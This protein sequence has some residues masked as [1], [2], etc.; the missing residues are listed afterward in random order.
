MTNDY[1][2]NQSGDLVCNKYDYELIDHKKSDVT[3]SDAHFIVHQTNCYAWDSRV[4]RE[5]YFTCA[6]KSF[7]RHLRDEC[8]PSKSYEAQA[9]RTIRV[10]FPYKIGCGLAAGK[11]DRYYEITQDFAHQCYIQLGVP[12]GLDGGYVREIAAACQAYEEAETPR[13]GGNTTEAGFSAAQRKELREII[14]EAFTQNGFHQ[15]DRNNISQLKSSVSDVEHEFKKAVAVAEGIAEWVGQASTDSPHLFNETEFITQTV[16]QFRIMAGHDFASIAAVVEDVYKVVYDLSKEGNEN[17]RRPR[18]EANRRRSA[19]FDL[20]PFPSNEDGE[21][22]DEFDEW[23]FKKSEPTQTSSTSPSLKY[24]SPAAISRIVQ[25]MRMQCSNRNQ[26]NTTT[27]DPGGAPQQDD[28]RARANSTAK[29][30]GQKKEETANGPAA[31]KGGR[32]PSNAAD[33]KTNED[34]AANT[35]GSLGLPLLGQGE[36]IGDYYIKNRKKIMSTLPD[37]LPKVNQENERRGIYHI[38]ADQTTFSAHSANTQLPALRQQAGILLQKE[39]E[40][41]S[42]INLNPKKYICKSLNNHHKD[43]LSYLRGGYA[44]FPVDQSHEPQA[45]TANGIFTHFTSPISTSHSLFSS[46]SSPTTAFATATCGAIVGLIPFS[47]KAGSELSI[48]THGEAAEEFIVAKLL[49]QNGIACVEVLMHIFRQCRRV[50]MK[51]ESPAAWPRHFQHLVSNVTGYMSPSVLHRVLNCM[52]AE[53]ARAILPVTGLRSSDTSLLTLM[54]CTAAVDPIHP[55]LS[56][57]VADFNSRVPTTETTTIE[58]AHHKRWPWAENTEKRDEFLNVF[59]KKGNATNLY[60][61]PFFHKIEPNSLEKLESGATAG[62]LGLMKEEFAKT[63]SESVEEYANTKWE[64]LDTGGWRDGQHTNYGCF[65]DQK[66]TQTKAKLPTYGSAWYPDEGYGEDW[67]EG[68]DALES[69]E[70]SSANDSGSDSEHEADT[71]TNHTGR[72]TQNPSS[73]AGPKGPGGSQPY[74]FQGAGS[75]RHE[76]NHPPRTAA[77]ERTN[78]ND[79][80]PATGRGRKVGF[81]HGE[82]RSKS[83]P[84]VVRSRSRRRA[85][86]PEANPSPRAESV[87]G[88]TNKRHRKHKKKTQKAKKSDPA[89]HTREYL[90]QFIGKG[91]ADEYEAVY[92]DADFIPHDVIPKVLIDGQGNLNSQAWRQILCDVEL[93]QETRKDALAAGDDDDFAAEYPPLYALQLSGMTAAIKFL[94]EEFEEATAFEII[95]CAAMSKLLAKKAIFSML[96]KYQTNSKCPYAKSDLK[97]PFQYLHKDDVIEGMTHVLKRLQA[98][99]GQDYEALGFDDAQRYKKLDK[100]L[101][102][103]LKEVKT[104]SSAL[105]VDPQME[106]PIEQAAILFKE[107]QMSE[108]IIVLVR[109]IS[110]NL[111]E[112]EALFTKRFTSLRKTIDRSGLYVAFIEGKSRPHA[113]VYLS[114]FLVANPFDDRATVQQITNKIREAAPAVFTRDKEPQI[115]YSASTPTSTKTPADHPVNPNNPHKGKKREAKKGKWNQQHKKGDGWHSTKKGA[116]KK[117]K[118]W[119]KSR[120][121][122][123]NK[124]GKWGK[125]DWNHNYWNPWDQNQGWNTPNNWN[126]SNNWSSKAPAAGNY[127]WNPNPNSEGAQG[128]LD[129][130]KEYCV[131]VISQKTGISADVIWAGHQDETYC[132]L[133]G[134]ELEGITRVGG[135]SAFCKNKIGCRWCHRNTEQLHGKQAPEPNPNSGGSC[136]GL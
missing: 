10:A 9:G 124:G 32:S 131:P 49:S 90:H 63:H 25:W 123:Y 42:D 118:S 40:L 51:G 15:G 83:A 18:S 4:E 121:G 81:E 79:P 68:D 37:F 106:G 35:A 54:V 34:P 60:F 104:Y 38:F 67:G 55:L 112:T 57:Q 6:L 97:F 21:E 117:N 122:P 41:L 92:E 13:A 114:D 127:G 69:S 116:G 86:T 64:M 134:A 133:Y 66:S 22:D 126:Y 82:Q 77:G 27:L 53:I 136:P 61:D 108:I 91:W 7:F 80:P 109:I 58:L 103:L 31:P 62:G 70:G 74:T 120:S 130:L 50:C 1:E 48:Q 128:G 65:L 115:S 3:K 105:G 24:Q 20:D 85:A 113:V 93:D 87:P 56:N 19:L 11:W 28:Q 5:Y 45:H 96:D 29:Q 47:N 17:Y 44:P 2:A 52:R 14:E 33:E 39:E 8:I 95:T 75:I 99:K 73:R 88:D 107:Y 119:D 110:P 135:A 30:K 84:R 23:G 59:N 89:K 26:T 46:S 94:V 100:A 98:Q 72:T 12:N 78:L 76:L 71:A 16:R 129:Q 132:I 43:V 102:D 36:K 125:N 111:W 101:R